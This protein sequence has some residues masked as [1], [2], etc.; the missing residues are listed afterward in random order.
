MALEIGLSEL[1]LNS[2]TTRHP[3]H[4][5]PDLHWQSH[6]IHALQEAAASL[7]VHLFEDMNLTFRLLLADAGAADISRYLLSVD[8]LRDVLTYQ[9]T[10]LPLKIF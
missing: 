1:S 7:L 5:S 4:R 9:P 6:A 2:H 3:Y 10:I 8:L